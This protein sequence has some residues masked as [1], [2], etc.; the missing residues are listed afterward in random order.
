MNSSLSVLIITKNA[1]QVLERTLLSIKNGADEI[2]LVD[3]FSKDDTAQIAHRHGVRVIKHREKDLGKQK[4]YGLTHA[5]GPWILLL[6]SDE[7]V[8]PKLA[9]EMRQVIKQ[10]KHAGFLIPY[11]NHFLNKPLKYGGENY[12]MLRLFKKNKI[13]IPSALVHEYVKLKTGTIGKL[14]NKIYHYSYRSLWQMYAK[15][16]IYGISEA[17]QKYANKERSSLKKITLYPLHMFYARFLKDKG[18]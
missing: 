5:R 10:T 18:Y 2:I 6:D 8:S 7:V 11:Q 9:Q 12:S 15:F 14:K 17:R 1:S 16:T 4:S 13:T 3:N